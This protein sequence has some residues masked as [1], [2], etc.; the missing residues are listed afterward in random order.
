MEG[1]VVARNELGSIEVTNGQSVKASAGQAPIMQLMAHPRDAVQWALYYPP[2]VYFAATEKSDELRQS[3]DAYRQGDLAQAFA[4]LA[5]RDNQQQSVHFYTYRATLYLTVGLIDRARVD[6]DQALK[7]QKA[8]ADALALKS[9]IATV[10]NELDSAI[11]LARQAVAADPRAA[12]P[13]IAQSYALQ[14]RFELQQ[15]RDAAKLAS[16]LEP[17]NALAWVRLAELWASL[18]DR[19][20]ALEA[21]NRAV[22]LDPE[23]S[24]TQT[25]LGFSYL[26]RLEMANAKAA[27]HKAIALDSADPVPRL[28]L[29]LAMIRQ[30][31]LAQGRHEMEIAADLDPLYALLRSYLAKA[32]LEEWRI[33]EAGVQLDLA[34]Q[35]DPYDPTPWLYAAIRKQMIN[36]PIEA[37]SD[38]D[39]SIALNDNRAVFRSRLLLQQDQAA[40]GVNLGR[41]Y[42]D[43]GFDQLETTAGWKAT[44]LDPANASAHEL[45]ADAYSRRSRHEIARVSEQLQA[46]ML[47]PL[48]VFPLRSLSF[49]S[50]SLL[51][52]NY[53]PANLSSGEYA[54]LFDQNGMGGRVSAFIG[55]NETRGDRIS[56]FGLTDRVSLLANQYHYQTDGFRENNDLTVD[57]YNLIGQIFLSDRNLLQLE[58][59]RE[60]RDNGDLDL[61]FDLDTFSPDNRENRK[62]SFFRIGHRYDLTPSTTLLSSLF[63]L[64]TDFEGQINEQNPTPFGPVTRTETNAENTDAYLAEFQVLS[65]G[66]KQQWIAGIGYFDEDGEAD[67]TRSFSALPSFP[68][69]SLLPPPELIPSE[70]QT[71]H[72]NG[73]LY[74]YSNLGEIQLVSGLSY[75]SLDYRSSTGQI[76]A[77]QFNPKLGMIWQPNGAFTFRIAGFRTL[78]GSIENNRSLQPTHVAGFNQFYD[79]LAGSDAKRIGVGMDYR[80]SSGHTM[81]AEISGR[82]LKVPLLS[83]DTEDEDERAFRGYYYMTLGSR[84]SAAVDLE[85]DRFERSPA[86]DEVRRPNALRTTRIPLNLNYHHPNGMYGNLGATHVRQ[87][88]DGLVVNGEASERFW[89]MDGKIGYRLPNRLGSVEAEVRN[90][91]DRD[92]NYFGDDFQTGTIPRLDFIPERTITISASINL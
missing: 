41:I 65:R 84:W 34:R 19:E 6:I 88:V 66:T 42:A 22:Q 15:A 76:E 46:N 45:L 14:A 24:R 51:Q 44:S 28:G 50:E 36:R 80:F 37:L 56:A 16:D 23:L 81:G 4:L 9:I 53:L 69:P 73:Y 40:R 57:V 17:T 61:L 8:S 7:I 58:I 18:D 21:A 30:G 38:L 82:S 79:D 89:T 59:Q 13:R 78:K 1:A 74:S 62:D 68:F 11:A 10:Q 12:A 26:I 43:L 55:S 63:Y 54:A 86:L 91:F 27:F 49:T 85:V 25:I 52:D 3:L 71:R 20:Q 32:Y 35:L 31:E 47:Q 48:S 67:T 70:S 29:G 2:V 33:A 64:N 92:F 72:G 87:K 83:G 90:L 75:D 5:E 60:E 77:S 39:R